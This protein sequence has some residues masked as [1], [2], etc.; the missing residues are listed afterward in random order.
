MQDG[1]LPT[2]DKDGERKPIVD[3]KTEGKSSAKERLLLGN[4]SQRTQETLWWTGGRSAV[5]KDDTNIKLEANGGLLT[6]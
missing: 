3:A 1:E 4:V 2:N 5:V 6:A